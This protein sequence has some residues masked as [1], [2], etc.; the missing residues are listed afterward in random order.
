VH[1]KDILDQLAG[2]GY[3]KYLSFK[4]IPNSF[5]IWSK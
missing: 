5:L 1:E 4:I 3:E 2:L